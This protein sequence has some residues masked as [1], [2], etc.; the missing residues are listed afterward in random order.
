MASLHFVS[1]PDR[2]KVCPIA[3]G[4][5]TLGRLAACDVQLKDEKASREHCRIWFDHTHKAYMLADLGSAN[6]TCLNAHLI[7]RETVLANQDEISFGATTIRFSRRTP[8]WDPS[9]LPGAL[10]SSIR[11]QELLVTM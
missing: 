8:V 1:G 7:R 9:D 2:G 5:F 6:G 4:T 3:G 10:E 11:G